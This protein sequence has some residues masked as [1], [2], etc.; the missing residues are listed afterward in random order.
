MAGKMSQAKIDKMVAKASKTSVT[1]VLDVM[2]QYRASAAVA[3]LCLANML[4]SPLDQV[5]RPASITL[6]GLAAC[7]PAANRYI[8]V[9]HGCRVCRVARRAR[10][11]AA[12][13][14]RLRGRC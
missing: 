8:I 2:D 3:S 5:L 14:P 6:A 4:G 12:V 11:G 7:L 10:C 13:A 1:A 9:L